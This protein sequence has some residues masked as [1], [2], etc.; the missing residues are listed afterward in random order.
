MG[1]NALLRLQSKITDKKRSFI[2][3]ADSKGFLNKKL[4]CYT[5][6]RQNSANRLRAGIVRVLLNL[7][8][9]YVLDLFSFSFDLSFPVRSICLYLR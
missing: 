3:F 2:L 1:E 7:S 8:S 4:M 9:R 5:K 6:F